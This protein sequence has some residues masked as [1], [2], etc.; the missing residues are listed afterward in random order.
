MNT[1]KLRLL[2]CWGS[3]GLAV[4]APLHAQEAAPPAP[5]E[6]EPIVRSGSR[7]HLAIYQ[8]EVGQPKTL[9]VRPISDPY[10]PNP[11]RPNY[12][13][14]NYRSS[15]S[16]RYS[17]ND[18]SSSTNYYSGNQSYYGITNGM[19]GGHTLHYRAQSPYFGEK[20]YDYTERY[21]FAATPTAPPYR[22]PFARDYYS[23][24]PAGTQF[25]YAFGYGY[26]IGPYF[27][28]FGYGWGIPWYYAWW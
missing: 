17:S 16:Y 26:P 9:R 13:S 18:H 22:Y 3:L 14:S 27:G 8:R 20:S 12:S 7:I 15:S 28:G 19:Y 6:E 10:R 2:I 25:G 24:G 4:C 5:P 23:Y 21:P 11:Y 1:A